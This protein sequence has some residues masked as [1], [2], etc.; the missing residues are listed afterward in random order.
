M[1]KL[2]P[3]L[4]E[5]KKEKVLKVLSEKNFDI[6]EKTESGVDL[7]G[8]VIVYSDLDVLEKL[9]NFPNKF[10]FDLNK[11]VSSISLVKMIEEESNHF[12]NKI[13]KY[14]DFIKMN[15]IQLDIDFKKF[16]DLLSYKK[17]TKS[18]ENPIN[19]KYI[20]K[21][22]ENNSSEIKKLN[23]FEVIQLISKVKDSNLLQLYFDIC[24]FENLPIQEHPSFLLLKDVIVNISQYCDYHIFSENKNLE[25]NNIN[26]ETIQ[27]IKEDF[28]KIK[29]AKDFAKY[30]KK[31]KGFIENITKLELLSQLEDE[32]INPKNEI[33]R[34][35]TSIQ[36]TLNTIFV[37]NPDKFMKAYLK[38]WPIE[39]FSEKSIK[40][41]ILSEKEK[42]KIN[43]ILSTNHIMN[44]IIHKDLNFEETYK[45]IIQS[46]NE[47]KKKFKLKDEEI[48][49]KELNIVFEN[50]TF[51][52]NVEGD[53]EIYDKKITIYHDYI[54]EK[55]GV[56]I[57]EYTHYLQYQAERDFIKLEKLK[58]KSKEWINYSSEDFTN[59]LYNQLLKTN[60]I[61]EN[62]IWK[63]LI[64]NCLMKAENTKDFL[65]YFKEI[66]RCMFQD[67]DEYNYLKNYTYENEILLI[68]SYYLSQKNKDYSFEHYLWKKLDKNS[69]N[70]KEYW[71]K[72]LE[73]H[74]RMNEAI[75]NKNKNK[76]YNEI[77]PEKLKQMLNMIESFNQLFVSKL[78]ANNKIKKKN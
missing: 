51:I 62:E 1:I 67:E 75:Y 30:F 23:P 55:I 42:N 60:I 17:N 20:K 35:Q 65:D 39:Y 10:K 44:I 8:A 69:K 14:Y 13:E 61:N 72:S 71:N 7:L 37:E 63:R 5:N 26:I 73:I 33:K 54:I 22:L 59:N 49:N 43:D 68:E 45:V 18:L 6:N 74:A 38:N 64:N 50:K 15:N 76:S 41:K 46:I 57:H 28:S 16:L 70:K 19:V 77:N 32:L 47:I 12:S 27:K 78:K 40:N 52:G 58:E 4:E 48:G 21:F 29:R 53:Y 25:D 9:L 34:L 31:N 24:E 11:L 56:F 66:A 2:I 3:L 36:K